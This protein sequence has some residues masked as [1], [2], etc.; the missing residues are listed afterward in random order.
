MNRLL[1]AL[2]LPAFSSFVFS[3]QAFANRPA[4]EANSEANNAAAEIV[5]DTQQTVDIIQL[6]AK[7]MQP[8][9][10]ITIKQLNFPRRGMSMD[11]V[12]NEYGQPETRSNSVGQPPITSWIYNDRIV[13]FEYSTVLHVVAR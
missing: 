11:K 1:T 8:G 5:V 4:A 13:Y 2:L 10:T 7:E 9:E 6:P 3:Q 12:I